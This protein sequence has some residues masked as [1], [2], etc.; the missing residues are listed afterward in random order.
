MVGLESKMALASRIILVLLFLALLRTLAEPLI[1]PVGPG[2]LKMLL[3]GALVAAF[4]CLVL[5]ALSFW[6]QYRWMLVVGGA[7][8]AAL[9][10]IKTVIQ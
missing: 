9:I 6:G 5:T 4:G 2:E 7:T 1:R 8:L 3:V 10:L